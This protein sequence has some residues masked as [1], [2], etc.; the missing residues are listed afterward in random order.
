MG[1]RSIQEPC[2]HQES[3]P[4]LLKTVIT[5]L[6]NLL[7]SSF[8]VI[9]IFV[10]NNDTSCNIVCEM[11]WV[12]H[13]AHIGVK[14]TAYKLLVRKPEGKRPLGRSRHRW[15][16]N[17]KIYLVEIAWHGVDWIGVVQDRYKRR[18]FVNTV[19]NLLVP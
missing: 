5:C 9:L 10:R 4:E 11:M 1:P 7:E 3:N 16:D 15:V 13:V 19:I 17:I 12:G 2:L 6:C 18:A 8:I 14:G